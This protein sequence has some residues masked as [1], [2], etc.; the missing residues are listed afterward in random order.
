MRDQELHLRLLKI[1]LAITLLSLIPAHALGWVKSA[2]YISELSILALLI[3]LVTWIET[4]AVRV[5][6][7]QE[8]V[9]GDVVEAMVEQTDV[10]RSP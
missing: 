9:A 7:Q 6:Q 8:E 1:A 3:S 10:E 5:T 4:K 2:V